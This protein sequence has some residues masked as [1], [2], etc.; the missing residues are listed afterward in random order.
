MNVPA[1]G[2]SEDLTPTLHNPN[3]ATI[4]PKRRQ[5]IADII[6]SGKTVLIEDDAY[7][8]L[9]RRHALAGVHSAL[10]LAS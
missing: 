10:I 4:P 1:C 6:R 7:G 3:P 9:H 8:W 5:A 2:V